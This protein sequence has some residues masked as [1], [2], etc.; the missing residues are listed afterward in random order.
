MAPRPSPTPRGRAV[1]VTSGGPRNPGELGFLLKL[2]GSRLSKEVRVSFGPERT[3]GSGPRAVGW[4]GVG[5]GLSWSLAE[6]ACG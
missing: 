3:V 6:T 4:G 5:W 2:P 1:V